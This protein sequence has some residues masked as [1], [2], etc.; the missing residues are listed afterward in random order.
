LY[1]YDLTTKQLSQLT[2]LFTGI[3][4][5]TMYAPAISISR[6]T[7]QIV[8]SYYSNRDYIVFSSPSSG[9]SKTPVDGSDVD[10]QAASLPPFERRSGSQVQH[11]MES[12]PP[13]SIEQTMAKEVPYRPRFGLDYIGNMGIGVQTG[14]GFGTGLAGGINGLFSDMLGN[15]QLYGS[16]S[17]NGEL[18]DVAGLFAYLNQKQRVNWGATISHIPYLSG[19]QYLFYDSLKG[20]NG[21]TTKVLNS[22]LELLRTFE[23]QVSM[24]AS[25]P[26]S[27]I[28]RIEAGLS[29]S[30]YYYRLDRY[31]DYYDPTGTYYIGSD[32][33]RE[34]TPGGFNFG[35]TYL[36][37][38]G[39]NSF[40][41]VASPLIGHRF[42][43]E[44]SQYFGVMNLTSLTA[45]VRKYFRVAPVTLATRS[46]FIGRYGPDA[47]N[48]VLPPLYIGYPFL[49]RGYDA[50]QYADDRKTLPLTINDLIGSKMYVGNLE[51]RLPLTGPERLSVVKSGFLFTEVNLF[52]DGGIAWGNRS[53]F[54]GPSKDPNPVVG[55][56]KFILSSGISLRIN[57]F[58]YLVLEPYYAIPWQNGG[59]RNGS[60]SIN[61]I[62]GW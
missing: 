52:T 14:A 27:T 3:S 37:F 7:D 31:S 47:G 46:M 29:F 49:V 43:F 10:R 19:A 44:A 38:V 59:L 8:Y 28:R 48:G 22:A 20:A 42:R 15:N 6:Q 45:D 18:V 35:N 12:P 17:M 54:L 2:D 40:F 4:G 41:G 51:L 34:P 26:F 39:D 16:L 5:I 62:P 58:G 57:L 25:Y 11:N 60:F 21:D 1:T 56:Q 61:I 32:K 53:L 55:N 30:R 33:K 50:L 24:F 13:L 36:A 9:F 23:D